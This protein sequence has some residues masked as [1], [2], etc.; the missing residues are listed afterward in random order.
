[1]LWKLR[2]AFSLI[3]FCFVAHGDVDA[4]LEAF[5]QFDKDGDQKLSFDELLA[6]TGGTSSDGMSTMFKNADSDS[7]GFLSP[8]ELRDLGKRSEDKGAKAWYDGK[9]EI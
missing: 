4:F 8:Q 6:M 1:M 7:D 3:A 2:R 9:D 5:N